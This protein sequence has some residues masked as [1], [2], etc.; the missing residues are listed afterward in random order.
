MCTKVFSKC[1]LLY[2][3]LGKLNPFH[4]KSVP[5]RKTMSSKTLTDR[6]H[7]RIQ[8]NM[9]TKLTVKLTANDEKHFHEF[10]FCENKNTL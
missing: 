10:L 9:K 3:I 1:Y 8:K 5:Q 7:F 4:E 6:H 2:K